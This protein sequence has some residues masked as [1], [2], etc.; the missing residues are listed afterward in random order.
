[1][2]TLD[3]KDLQVGMRVITRDEKRTGTVKGLDVGRNKIG[4]IL[5]GDTKATLECD[6]AE[7]KIL[8]TLELRLPGRPPPNTIP[9][10]PSGGQ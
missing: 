3:A 8:T 5:D 6:P 1:M 4:V 2:K 10:S 9:R 7:F